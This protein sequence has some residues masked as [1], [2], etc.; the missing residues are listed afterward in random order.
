MEYKITKRYG[1]KVSIDYQSYDFIT[2]LTKTI[3]VNSAEDLIN[4]ND[5]LFNQC[6]ALTETDIEASRSKMQPQE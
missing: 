3:N 4:E 1:R 5:K 2:E 6:V